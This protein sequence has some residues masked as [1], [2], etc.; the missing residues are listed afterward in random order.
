M[1]S[2][3]PTV[4]EFEFD[5][6]NLIHL[7]MTLEVNDCKEDQTEM[8]WHLVSKAAIQL[9]A[10][11]RI[12]WFSTTGGLPKPFKN[13]FFFSLMKQYFRFKGF[14]LTIFAPNLVL[15]YSGPKSRKITVTKKNRSSE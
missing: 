14:T 9:L 6:I 7:F 15:I 2:T 8:K 13:V 12:C 5:A 11:R 10:T 4:S 3:N 1:I